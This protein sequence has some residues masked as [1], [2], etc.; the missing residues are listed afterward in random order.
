MSVDVIR[1]STI[2]SVS[3]VT[4]EM[5]LPKHESSLKNA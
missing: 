1:G 4:D 2:F 5:M 3:V